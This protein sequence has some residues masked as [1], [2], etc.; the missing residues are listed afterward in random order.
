[1]VLTGHGILFH[2]NQGF[3]R[4]FGGLRLPR[5]V[6]DLGMLARVLLPAARPNARAAVLA[7]DVEPPELQ[8]PALT[9]HQV[10]GN[11]R[12]DLLIL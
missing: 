4:V 3:C 11:H 2:P 12:P 5:C 7:I 9:R 1:M 6:H 8:Y 10:A